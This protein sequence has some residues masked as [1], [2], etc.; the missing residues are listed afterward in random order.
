VIFQLNYKD[1]NLLQNI[2]SHF[3]VGSIRLRIKN[4]VP[5]SA[6]FSV[7]SIKDLLEI[8]IPHFD[9]YPLLT[10]KRIDF[11]LFKQIV[12]LMNNK[13]HLTLEALETVVS[14]RM[15][16]TKLI[17]EHLKLHFSHISKSNFS[18]DLTYLQPNLE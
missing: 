6:I 9:K 5:K 4:D 8:I 14:L 7:R 3:G 18:L 11:L 17:P 2:K 10:Q 12:I 15:G 13:Q 1:L 16:M